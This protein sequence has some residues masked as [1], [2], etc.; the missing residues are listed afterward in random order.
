MKVPMNAMKNVPD[1]SYVQQVNSRHQFSEKVFK[2]Y[3]QQN[4]FA[5]LWRKFRKYT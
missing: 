1:L 5:L 4:G 2:K 3:L